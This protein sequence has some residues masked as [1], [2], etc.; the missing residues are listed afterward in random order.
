MVFAS[1]VGAMAGCA[2]N[3]TVP[4][5]GGFEPSEA[6]LQLSEVHVASPPGAAVRQGSSYP[7]ST[8]RLGL[9]LVD[10]SGEPRAYLKTKAGPVM[11]AGTA[12][13]HNYQ[14]GTGDVLELTVFKVPELSRTLQVASTGTINMPLIGD[15]K[16]SGATPEQLERQLEQR[17]GMK[18]L[19]NPQV[20]VF[21]KDY[22]SQKITVEGSVKKPG[23]FPLRGPTTLLQSLA[24]AGGLS[25]LSDETNVV[26]FRTIGTTRSA[27]RFDVTAIRTGKTTD[28]LLKTGDLVVAHQSSAKQAFESFVKVIPIARVFVPVL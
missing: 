19:V 26:I 10:P 23:M 1:L 13:M 25:A 3:T 18:Y 16:A 12:S 9:S 21:V 8:P 17:L 2:A 27:A 24:Q 11:T 5:S 22:N 28:P 4:L 15:L 7:H 6:T 14:I 20:Q